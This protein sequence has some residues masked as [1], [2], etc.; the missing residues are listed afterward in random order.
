MSAR[1]RRQFNGGNWEIERWVSGYWS[2]AHRRDGH[3]RPSGIGARDATRQHHIAPT[4]LFPALNVSDLD[5]AIKFYGDVLGMKVAAR[6][7][8]AGGNR[9]EVNLTFTGTQ[10]TSS[11]VLVYD[12]DRKEPL[13]QGTAFARVAVHVDDA[14]AVVAKCKAF[15]GCTVMREPT[16]GSSNQ[17]AMIK[18]PEGFSYEVIQ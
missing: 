11:L 1:A 8:S 7:P 4:V 9:V 2:G 17:I 10:S 13:T 3:Q 18:D 6:Y 14:M 5:R 16:P 15:P 12:K